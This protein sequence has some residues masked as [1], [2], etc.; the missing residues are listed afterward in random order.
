LQLDFHAKLREFSALADLAHQR[1]SVTVGGWNVS[2]KEALSYE[3]T[4]DAITSELNGDTSGASI[5]NSAFGKR[6]ESLVHTVP[7]SSQE[8]QAEAEAYFKMSARRFVTGRGVA[9]TSKDLRVGS[10]VNLQ[11]LGPLFSGKYY[12]SEVRHLFDL[13]LGL[14]SEFTAERPGL[15]QPSG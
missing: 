3:A 1:T 15:G 8:T 7:M 9:E 12:L 2:S 13:R 6:K 11:G 5:L 10:Y 4:E 14:R